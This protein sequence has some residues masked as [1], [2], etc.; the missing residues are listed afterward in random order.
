MRRW[1]GGGLRRGMLEGVGLLLKSPRR[2]SSPATEPQAEG[3]NT[4]H[5][6]AEIMTSVGVRVQRT[7]KPHLL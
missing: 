1:G 5:E 4:G 7:V 3:T 2:P 6:N